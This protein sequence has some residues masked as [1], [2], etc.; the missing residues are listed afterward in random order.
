[1][2]DK[3]ASLTLVAMQVT[4]HYISDIN[5]IE[6]YQTCL[7]LA[8]KWSAVKIQLAFFLVNHTGSKYLPHGSFI[9][10][11]LNKDDQQLISHNVALSH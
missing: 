1:M 9:S 7:P 5:T 8:V 2:H 3:C 6:M 4:A 11:L 10:C